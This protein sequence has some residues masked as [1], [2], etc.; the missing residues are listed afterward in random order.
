MIIERFDFLKHN[1]LLDDYL[2]SIEKN[3][4]IFVFSLF[5]LEMLNTTKE[6]NLIINNNKIINLYYV[7]NVN[8][9]IRFLY[10]YPIKEY[11]FLKKY[12]SVGISFLN[13]SNFNKLKLKRFYYASEMIINNKDIILLENKG[14]K[15]VFKK[16]NHFKNNYK[17][18]FE[19]FDKNKV[20]KKDLLNFFIK[21]KE[22]ALEYRNKLK[23]NVK[24]DFNLI[25]LIYDNSYYVDNGIIK[26]I[27]L[28]VDSEIIGVCFYI[29]SP[30]QKYSISLTSKVNVKFSGASEYLHYLACKN[31]FCEKDVIFQNIGNLPYG[32]I[33]RFKG[34]FNGSIIK[35]YFGIYYEKEGFEIRNV[36]YWIF[37]HI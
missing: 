37:D 4:L 10:E 15:N 16:I 3:D 27:I 29:F 14:L 20:L 24:N 25:N 11:D 34:K 30:N 28:K 19:L 5:Q 21:W 13:E 32:P 31:Q 26:G 1:K 12:N 17:Y 2:K 22:Y 9:V 23:A 35:I 8:S 7:D 33:N 18:S 6:I 36:D